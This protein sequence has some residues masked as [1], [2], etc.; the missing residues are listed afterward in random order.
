MAHMDQLFIGH[1]ASAADASADYDAVAAAHES[2]ATGHLEA[3]VV[4][5]GQG[6]GLTLERHAKM[7]GMHLGHGPS[8]ELKV[9][10]QEI[11]R[12]T[13]ALLV[14]STPDDA[15]HVDAAVTRATSRAS[16]HVDGDSAGNVAF[17]VEDS[18]P[19]DEIGGGPPIAY[20]VGPSDTGSRSEGRL[21]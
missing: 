2:G 5:R 14:V 4:A 10:T 12:G 17:G 21:T 13:V 18:P 1:Y 16:H 19:D 20:D 9:G 3:A 15:K 6:G 7:G 11:E 8:N